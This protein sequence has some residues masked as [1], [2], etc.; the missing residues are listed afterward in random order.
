MRAVGPDDGGPAGAH[1]GS[2]DLHGLA[3]GCQRLVAQRRQLRRHRRRRRRHRRCCCRATAA[4]GAVVRPLGAGVLGGRRRRLLVLLQAL[5]LLRLRRL[6]LRRG[7]RCIRR[8]ARLCLPRDVAARH[9]HCRE[10]Q[11]AAADG[12]AGGALLSRRQLPFQLRP[13]LLRP[14]VAAGQQRAP[15]VLP[16]Q[17]AGTHAAVLAGAGAGGQAE[18]RQSGGAGRQKLVAAGGAAVVGGAACRRAA[19]RRRESG[20]LGVPRP[21]GGLQAAR[22]PAVIARARRAR[23]HSQAV[24]KMACCLQP[25]GWAA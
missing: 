22:E 16:L 4:A 1:H 11:P 24:R 25:P 3:R 19:R 14:L 12:H 15:Q 20:L 17:Q 2:K 9:R 23:P 18:Q 21:W 6:L 7:C 8:L 5:L 10:L 13:C